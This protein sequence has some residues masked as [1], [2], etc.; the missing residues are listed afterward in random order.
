MYKN[1]FKKFNG[2]NIP[3]IIE[4]I[5]EYINNDPSIT[6]SIGCDSIQKQRRTT[7][8]ITIVFHNKFVKNGAHVVFFRESC[9]KIKDNNER[10]YKEAQYLYDVGMYL[11]DELSKY[12]TR[13]DIDDYERKKYKYHLLKCD[14]KYHNIN[15]YDDDNIIKNINLDL[16]DTVNFRFVDIHVDFN[17]FEG[18]INEKGIRKNKSYLAYK[19][20]V[21]WLRS[22]GFRVLAKPIAY[23]STSAADLLLQS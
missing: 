8:A 13:Q 15:S 2:Q 22:L 16:S 9:D 23:A 6:I 4:Y 18:K 5:R 12:Y 7:Y 1:R 19:S 3:D 17:P 11:D 20:Y 10:L 21:P 14:G